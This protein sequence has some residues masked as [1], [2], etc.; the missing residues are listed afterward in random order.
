MSDDE[1]IAA[2][3]ADGEL[4]EPTEVDTASDSEQETEQEAKP[5]DK[6]DSKEE[7]EES[8]EDKDLRDIRNKYK[9]VLDG[10]SDEEQLKFVSKIYWDTNNRAAATA[11]E[12]K[13][14]QRKHDEMLAQMREI[15]EAKTKED[16]KPE[17]PPPDVVRIE[18]R[19]ARLSSEIT[20]EQADR[21]SL[22]Q[23]WNAQNV[24][25]IKSQALA[26][27][28]D[29]VSKERLQAIMEREAEKL[30]SLFDRYKSVE[31]TL[32][33]LAVDV[34][35]EQSELEK[36]K[37]YFSKQREDHSNRER[38]QKAQ[39]Q[40][41]L[42]AASLAFNVAVHATIDEYGLVG[43]DAVKF[44]DFAKAAVM[45]AL[46]DSMRQGKNHMSPDEIEVISKQCLE[47]LVNFK[48]LRIA[49][50]FTK[51]SQQKAETQAALKTVK[52]AGSKADDDDFTP[53]PIPRSQAWHDAQA[54][55]IL[56][57]ARAKYESA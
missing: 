54:R 49:Q 10:K 24:K 15:Q 14:L 31:K 21:D 4:E 44:Y 1:T 11:K 57:E 33:K 8:E 50:A 29:E 34:E 53:G 36:A 17:P 7:P 12:L 30:N 42:D 22:L 37:Q 45:Q 56:Q 28:A 43:K 35:D 23:Q 5:S 26:E 32:R 13:S 41:A 25:F 27:N 48:G 47:E 55:K 2:P 51:G 52:S 16:A 9:K 19:I 38:E 6:S 20:T 46:D 18:K 40:E 39:E 3:S